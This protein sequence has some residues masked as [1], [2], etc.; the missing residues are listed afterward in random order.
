[1]KIKFLLFALFLIVYLGGSLLFY[2]KG[3]KD[4]IKASFKGTIEKI[5]YDEKSIAD[6]Y[7]KGEKHHLTILGKEFKQR[8][9]VGDFIEKKTGVAFYTIKKPATGEIINFKF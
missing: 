8:V 4:L 3:R 1:M 9:R 6:V 5:T 2:A 7:V